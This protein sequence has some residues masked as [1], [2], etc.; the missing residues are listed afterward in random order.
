MSSMRSASSMTSISTPVS[1]SLP[2][3]K[4]SSNRPGVAMTT[5]APRSILAAC[6]VEGNPADQ[7]RDRQAMLLAERL[8]GS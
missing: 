4:W 8:E 2:R 7:Q 5:S 1:N 6:F 3:S